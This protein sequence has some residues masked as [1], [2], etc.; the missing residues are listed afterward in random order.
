MFV[1]V[2]V[3]VGLQAFLHEENPQETFFGSH[4]AQLKAIKDKFDPIGM[5]V[6]AEGV[7]SEDFDVSLNCRV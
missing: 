1:K 5:F 6:V 3:D 2:G 4:Y 7:G